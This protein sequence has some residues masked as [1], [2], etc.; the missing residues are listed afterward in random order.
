MRERTLA[1]AIGSAVLL[2][3]LTL[4]AAAQ[5]RYPGTSWDRAASP[6]SMGW[7]ADKLRAAREYAATLHTAAVMVIA[8]G[9][10]LDE[11][12]ETTRRFGIHSIRKSLLS[13]LYGI[14]VKEGRIQ[15]GK[16]LGEL[17]IDDNEPSLTALEKR[18]T[19]GDLLKARS[20][21]YHPALYET[22]GMAAAR[23]ARGSYP[24]GAFWYYNNWDFNALGTIF[25]QATKT[26]IFEQLK[27]RLA[28]P[29]QMEDYRVEDG[30][31]VRGAESIHPAYPLRM[32][33]RDLARFGLLYL[34][35]GA[36]RGR[37]VVPKAWVEE[38][39]RSYSDRGQWG[40]YGY[41]WWVAP[42]GGPLL[43][44]ATFKARAYMA[45]GASGHFVVVVPYL[46]LVV[47]HRVNTDIQGRN[48]SYSQF[49]RLMQ[50]ILDAKK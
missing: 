45:E 48:V 42:N 43:T 29:L 38:S 1:R 10:V 8:D 20:G 44:S 46:D 49:G 27:T 16:T 47:V 18:A 24:P 12:G 9:V 21:V 28:D 4:P 36:W 2:V 39:T 26:S 37:Q 30:S 17:G 19:V 22:P 14:E 11:W 15:L 34:R 40:G 31:Y 23:P 35:D 5:P 50:L 33:A 32:T 25:E 7:S 41:M 6:E 13:A 3:L